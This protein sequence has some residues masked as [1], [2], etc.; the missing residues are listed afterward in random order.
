MKKNWIFFLG[1]GAWVTLIASFFELTS[2]PVF[3]SFLNKI[4]SQP[5][6]FTSGLA[7]ILMG[8]VIWYI[9]K[10][11]ELGKKEVS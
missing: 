2:I 7:V 10:G 8:I 6:P 1:V 4:M 5:N 9:L 11:I 3:K